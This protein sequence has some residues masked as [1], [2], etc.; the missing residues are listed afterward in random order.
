MSLSPPPLC[1]SPLQP[2]L[3]VVGVPGLCRCIPHVHAT[4]GKAPVYDDLNK[5]P[6]YPEPREK[7]PRE[8][9]TT[10]RVLRSFGGHRLTGT[11]AGKLWTERASHTCRSWPTR[12]SM[13][14]PS[15]GPSG[16]HWPPPLAQVSFPYCFSI[17]NVNTFRASGEHVAG[18]GLTLLGW[19]TAF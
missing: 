10:N 11:F 3:F 5:E 13:P 8:I 16:M 1:S 2:P 7:S 18:R 19:S 14:A 9:T 6:E 15:T 12:P 17:R 4:A